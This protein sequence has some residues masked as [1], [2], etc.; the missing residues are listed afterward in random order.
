MENSK[1]AAHLALLALYIW[2][3]GSD[4]WLQPPDRQVTPPPL[5]KPERLPTSA[6]PPLDG[7]TLQ[8]HFYLVKLKRRW[9]IDGGNDT[10]VARGNERPTPGS[11]LS[12]L[13]LMESA[14]KDDTWQLTGP[15][16]DWGGGGCARTR[17]E[18]GGVGGGA[19]GGEEKEK[20]NNHKAEGKCCGA[21]WPLA[22]QTTC[23][24][25][26]FGFTAA[27]QQEV[28]RASF[29]HIHSFFLRFSSSNAAQPNCN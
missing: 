2:F 14:N 7:R 10:S 19:G 6:S 24:A 26:A 20:I 21:T 13:W 27:H 11:L 9:I 25:L 1:A 5:R 22:D 4:L 18:G 23:W 29:G 17:W 3:R 8:G 28:T 15:V 12:L 16:T